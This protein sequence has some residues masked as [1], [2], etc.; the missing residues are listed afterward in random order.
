MV[1][2]EKNRFCRRDNHIMSCVVMFYIEYISVYMAQYFEIDSA[3]KPFPKSKHVIF[4]IANSL[5]III[6]N[7]GTSGRRAQRCRPNRS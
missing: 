2:R 3:E 1:R 5:T 4:C 7:D 6:Q